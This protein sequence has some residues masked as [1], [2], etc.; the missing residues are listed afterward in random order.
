M[1]TEGREIDEWLFEHLFRAHYADLCRYASRFLS[2]QQAVED[3]V[4][5]FFVALWENKNLSVTAENFLPYAYRAVYNRCLNYYKAELTKENFLTSLAEVW[6][7]DTEE[8]EF[9]YKK[10]V[11]AALRKL[12]PKCQLVFRTYFY[13]GKDVETIAADMNMAVS[14]VRTHL[15]RAYAFLRQSLKHLLLFLCLFL[16]S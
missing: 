9:P 5:S 7:K 6:E 15:K 8:E 12:P 2:D 11:R 13:A 4:Q 10:E 14:T 3:I 1:E 16:F